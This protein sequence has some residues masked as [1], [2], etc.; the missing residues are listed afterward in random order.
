MTIRHMR[1]FV[2]VYQEMNITRAAERLHMTQ[3]AVTRSIQ[4]LE[5][6]Y[7]L[8]LFERLRHRLH[9]A[10]GSEA[11]YARALHIVQA[12]D[13]LEQGARGQGGVLR[14]GASITL[15]SCFVPSLVKSMQKK[16]P[17][18]LIRV[19]VCNTRQ[20]CQALLQNEIDIGLVEGEASSEYLHAEVLAENRLQAVVPPGNPLLSQSSICLSDLAGQP[21][22]LREEGSAGRA[23]LDQVFAF[24]GLSVEPLWES[25]STQAL[26]N[27]V[28]AGLGVSIL[29]EKLVRS[30]I[31]TG[32][33]IPL[34]LRDEP[35]IRRDFILWH[36][37]KYLNLQAQALIEE[38]RRLAITAE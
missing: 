7:G 31:Q 23:F 16:Q 2:T 4:E 14:L 20:V 5:A 17:E 33:V 29:P 30:A 28:A 9:P 19:R 21:L 6:A 13:E 34:S 10:P 11:F 18:L 32:R 12:F 27:A 26:V 36:R 22:L 35:F 8:R 37:Q 24:H 15:G 1:I 25:V 3:P 38:A